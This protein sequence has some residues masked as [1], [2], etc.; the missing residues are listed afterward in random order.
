M[1]K[2]A[3]WVVAVVAALVIVLLVAYARGQEHHHGDEIGALTATAA[4]V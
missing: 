2:T 1:N 4:V 3:R